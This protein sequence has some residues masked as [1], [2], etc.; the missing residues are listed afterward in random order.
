MIRAYSF[1]LARGLIMAGFLTAVLA[2]GTI[3]MV[4]TASARVSSDFPAA[5]IAFLGH[6]SRESFTVLAQKKRYQN[7]RR[8]KRYQNRRERNSRSLNNRQSNSA[9]SSGRAASLGSVAR[10]VRRRVPGQLL[11]AR[12]VKDRRG[13]LTYRLKILGRNGVMRNV[14][15]DAYSGAI[16]GVR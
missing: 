11:D 16:L 3:T 9:V 14:T 7:R 15:A 1:S 12:L 10:S 4:S 8:D 2:F 5:E 13:K 6:N